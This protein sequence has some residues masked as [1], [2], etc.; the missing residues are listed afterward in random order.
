MSRFEIG[1]W[2]NYLLGNEI[3]SKYW[4]GKGSD[5]GQRTLCDFAFDEAS[6]STF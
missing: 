6:S 3:L 5:D 4:K 2:E 1:D